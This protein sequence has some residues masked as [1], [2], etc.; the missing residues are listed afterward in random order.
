MK[1]TF[2]QQNRKKNIKRHTF[3]GLWHILVLT[4]YVAESDISWP[5][6]FFSVYGI[7]KL[8]YHNT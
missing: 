6:S 1:L 5:H 2:N 3:L 4:C 8:R 7:A